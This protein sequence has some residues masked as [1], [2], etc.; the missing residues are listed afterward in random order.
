VP[1]IVIV[2]E[3][4]VFPQRIVTGGLMSIEALRGDLLFQERL[5]VGTLGFLSRLDA[6][7]RDVLA[8]NDV[9]EPPMVSKSLTKSNCMSWIIAFTEFQSRFNLEQLQNQ[10]ENQ[11]SLKA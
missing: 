1:L 7:N 9:I 4:D 6:L 2:H 8:Q 5:D 3:A 11:S 10:R